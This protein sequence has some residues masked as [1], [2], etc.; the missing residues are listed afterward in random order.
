MLV[1]CRLAVTRR[2]SFLLSSH[3]RG[4]LPP[5]SSFLSPLSIRSQSFSMFAQAVKNATANAPARK[6]PVTLSQQLLPSSSPSAPTPGNRRNNTLAPNL[7]A[8]NRQL[9]ADA[10]ANPLKRSATEAY[11]PV[12]RT[13]HGSK[14]TITAPAASSTSG[15]LDMLHNG[16][17]FDENDFVDDNEIDLDAED[18]IFPAPKRPC[19]TA[20]PNTASF[21]TPAKPATALAPP[22]SSV[23]I[24]W[25]SSPLSH[26]LPAV[27]A[28][29]QHTGV[30]KTQDK[31]S[32]PQIPQEE[33][34]KPARRRNLPWLNN[35]DETKSSRASKSTERPKKPRGKGASMIQEAS[36]TPA[37]ETPQA[38]WNKTASAIKAEQQKLKQRAN[39][40]KKR[41]KESEPDLP[42]DSK[43][44]RAT[45]TSRKGGNPIVLSAE[46]TQVLSLVAEEKKSVFFT[47]SAGTGK[48]VLM[49]EIIRNLRNKYVKESDRI[50]VTASTGLAAC[51]IGGVTLHS[52]AGI[53]LGKEPAEQ[54]VK[55]IKKN[56]KTKNRWLRTKVLIIDEISMIDGDL[57]D[58]LEAV[59]RAIRNNARPFGGLQL[60][61]TGDFFQ[62][63]PVPDHGKL[64]KFAFE[65]NT[66]STSI[67]H[68]IGLT[69]IFRQKDPGKLCPP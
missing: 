45:K 26:K 25:S 35:D 20:N 19:S 68:T 57:F 49:R 55:K 52:F 14:I 4:A 69:Q 59:A 51:N 12:T 62:L 50:A 39:S 48:S 44:R 7:S 31:I 43:G 22:A 9:P 33:D 1:A 29:A 38:P 53:G 37:K 5:L 17:S 40:G 30:N 54:L 41:I 42:A 67:E 36:E 2:T 27:P 6:G 28:L 61:V 23:P 66:W 32:Y 64:A 10:A 46:Q 13:Q 60:V 15:C 24:P 65:A 56:A 47:G 63:P 3:D 11:Q 18:D 34:E 58:K 21:A 8:G 16:V